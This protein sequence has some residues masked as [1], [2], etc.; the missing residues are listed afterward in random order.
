MYLQTLSPALSLKKGKGDMTQ[1][2]H[3]SPPFLR[4]GLGEGYNT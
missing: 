1:K 4:E 2:G 3:I